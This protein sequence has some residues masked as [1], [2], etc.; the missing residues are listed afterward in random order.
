MAFAD[1][2]YYAVVFQ[3]GD[4]SHT[5]GVRSQEDQKLMKHLEQ[6]IAHMT[7]KPYIEGSGGAW[8]ITK[9]YPL[10]SDAAEGQ[11]QLAKITADNV[12]ANPNHIDLRYRVQNALDEERTGVVSSTGADVTSVFDDTYADKPKRP[13]TPP[14]LGSPVPAPAP[15]PTNPPVAVAIQ[16]P[17]EPAATG[18]P[19]PDAI[20]AAVETPAQ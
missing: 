15:Q 19:G 6:S 1:M 20:A 17:I 9:V 12:A 18:V 7:R 16:T 13:P 4:Y 10:S 2:K 14:T 11:A 5:I 8:Q 3:W